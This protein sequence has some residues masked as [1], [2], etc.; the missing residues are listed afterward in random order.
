MYV[1]IY[2]YIYIYIYGHIFTLAPGNFMVLSEINKQQRFLRLIL[3][4][5]RI[6]YLVPLSLS[7]SIEI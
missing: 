4:T 6:I 5:L 7:L 3:L 1:Y 2:I